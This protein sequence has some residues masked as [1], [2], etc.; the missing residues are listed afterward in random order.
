MVSRVERRRSTLYFVGIAAQPG[1]TRWVVKQPR[2]ATRQH[3]LASPLTAQAQYDALV[4]LH[5][6]L[7]GQ[8][9][10]FSAPRPIAHLAEVGAF[11]MEFV[12]GRSIPQ[13]VHARAVLK[14]RPALDAVRSAAALLQALHADSTGAGAFIDHEKLAND[15]LVDGGRVLQRVGLPVRPSWFDATPQ[16]QHTQTSVL[17]HGDFAPENVVITPGATYCLDPALSWTRPAGARRR[18]VLDDALRRAAV[19]PHARRRSHRPTPSPNRGRVRR[20]VL[21]RRRAADQ[22]AAD[23]R[24]R[25]RLAVGAAP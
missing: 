20:N 3:D 11:A 22:P 2:T 16:P 12:E 18:P 25:H 5:D 15:G 6:V 19:H 17:L 13:L 9:P 24:A 14:P 10:H 23:A 1:T 7:N 21:R 4:V 8:D